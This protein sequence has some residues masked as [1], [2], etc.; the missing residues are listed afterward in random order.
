MSAFGGKSD[1]FCSCACAAGISAF[2]RF[3][4][5][6]GINSGVNIR[7]NGVRALRG[8]LKEFTPTAW[9]LFTET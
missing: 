4:N 8:A 6:L 7:V 5:A 2:F 3:K 1:A 9:S